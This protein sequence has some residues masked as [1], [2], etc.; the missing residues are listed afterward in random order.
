[1]NTRACLALFFLPLL[2]CAGNGQ[3]PPAAL[4]V[5]ELPPVPPLPTWPDDPP[6][7]EKMNLGSLLFFDQRLSGHGHINCN[8]C[9][10]YLTNFQDNLIGSSPDRSY[11]NGIPTLTRNTLSFYNIVYAP[12]MRWDGSQTDLA[13]AMAFPFSEP[14]M[15]LGTDVP[16]AQA[17]LKQRLTV[18][19]PGYVA[20]FMTAF[21]LDI[22]TLPAEEVWQLAGRALAAFVRLAVSR[23]AAFDRWNAGDDT[24]MSAQAVQGLAVFRGK[25]L[26]ISCHNGPLFTDYNF[27]NLSTAPPDPSGKRADEGRAVV[28]GNPKDGG[29]FLTPTLRGVYDTFPYF[30]DGSIPSLP[31]VLGFFSSAAVTADPNHDP[32]LDTPLPLTSDDIA[33]L[34]EFLKALRG[35]PLDDIS[36]PTAFP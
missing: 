20:Q 30:H 12:V 14:N 3:M 4:R 19:A 6:T 23:D 21:G 33:N 27:H 13:F 22:S 9:H 11:P 28:T 26:C 24:A 5:P 2:C 8:A 29:A 31:G 7:P 25:G 35:Q 1:M 32:L 36:P 15:N 18:D 16:S 17:G 10:T 34:V